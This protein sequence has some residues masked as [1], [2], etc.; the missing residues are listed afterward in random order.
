MGNKAPKEVK[1]L[2]NKDLNYLM[3][4]TGYTRDEIFSWHDSFMKD[5]PN[6]KLSRRQFYKVYKQL[7]PY[8]KPLKYSNRIFD[9][10]D[11]DQDNYINFFEF[12]V[13]LNITM[14]GNLEEKLKCAFKIYDLDGDGMIDKREMK[15]TLFS[16][17]ELIGEDVKQ[18]R[19]TRTTE[20]KVDYIFQKLDLNRDNYI[21]LNEFIDGCLK[22][23]YLR[24]L[25][26]T[27]FNTSY[28]SNNSN[29]N[30]FNSSSTLSL[31]TS[32]VA[33]SQTESRK[34]SVATAFSDDSLQSAALSSFTES[35]YQEDNDE[36]LEITKL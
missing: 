29:L 18:L 5:C 15:S 9:T 24:E 7:Y 8:G 23:E 21:T 31:A 3:K 12:I 17:Y 26:N 14:H 36:C 6:G 13:S 33:T 16:I 11:H 22:D 35:S 30:K 28:Y 34:C 4:L 25:L 20:K 32:S 10:F 2:D 27:T 19:R 1:S